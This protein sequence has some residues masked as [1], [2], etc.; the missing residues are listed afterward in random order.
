MKEKHT[1]RIE[2]KGIFYN[3]LE[4]FDRERIRQHLQDLLEQEV[5][6]WLGREKGKRKV[7][8]KEEPGYRNGYGRPRRFTL[9]LGTLV[10]RRPRVRLAGSDRTL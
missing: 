7:K 5:T 2:S 6:E 4:E 9:S 8:A 10:V 3:E 1:E